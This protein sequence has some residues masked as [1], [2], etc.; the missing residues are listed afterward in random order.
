MPFK[1]FTLDQE[2]KKK[3]VDWIN[4]KCNALTCEACKQNNWVMPDDAVMPIA[5]NGSINLGG[6]TY[7]QAML[8]C[9]N[10]GNTKYFNLA[11]MGLINDKEMEEDDGK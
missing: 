6:S 4:S 7:P 8:V 9:R 5:Y 10:C 2:K 3:I 11:L 1:K